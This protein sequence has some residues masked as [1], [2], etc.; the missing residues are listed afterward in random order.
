MTWLPHETS[1]NKYEKAYLLS[2]HLSLFLLQ[3]KCPQ[4]SGCVYINRLSS[5]LSDISY[6]LTLDADLQASRV[7]SRG[8]FTKNS[9]RFLTENAKISSTPLCRDYQVYVQVNG[10]SS[11]SRR[12]ASLIIFLYIWPPV[13]LSIWPLQ[14]ETPD[15]VNS[16]S[17]KV[18][19]EQ[20]NP[21]AN[22]VLDVFSPKA[23]Q[24]FVSDWQSLFSGDLRQTYPKHISWQRTLNMLVI[25]CECWVFT[26]SFKMTRYLYVCVCVCVIITGFQYLSVSVSHA[27][28]ANVHATQ[29]PQ[30]QN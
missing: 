13:H 11:C 10:W 16:L 26:Q 24:F 9:E 23:S 17:L 20:Q 8:M 4:L 22:P 14:Q 19:I 29:F 27:G 6:T 21:N 25:L 1:S 2:S 28:F 5:F 30:K 7:T 12:R 18:E 3:K 15:F